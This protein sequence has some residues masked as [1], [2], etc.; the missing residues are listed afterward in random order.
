[1]TD[2]SFIRLTLNDFAKAK[3]S[4]NPA[5][6]KLNYQGFIVQKPSETFLQISN[7][8][9]NISFVGGITVDLVDG[10]ENVVKNINYNFYY[11]GFVDSNGISQI[12]FEFGYIGVDYWT[13]PLYLRITDDINGNKWYSNNFLVTDYLTNIS[14]RFDYTNIGKIY[15]IS[16]DLANYTQ[17]VRIANCYDETPI[18]KKEVKQYITSQGLQVNYRPITTF[19][20]KYLINAFDYFI[21]DRLEVLFSHQTIYANDQR[22]VV[23]DFNYDERKGDSNWLSGDFTINPQN[24]IYSNNPQ[25]FPDLEVT[26]LLPVNN[27]MFSIGQK[28]SLGNGGFIQIQFNL[29]ITLVS[30]IT[31]KLYKDEVLVATVTPTVSA[32]V[33]LISNF[34][35]YF[36][37]LAN[38]SY[39]VVI[40][41]NLVKSVSSFWSGFPLLGQYHFDVVDGEYDNSEYNNNEY[42]VD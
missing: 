42:I 16:Y 20:R 39:D 28:T 14:T 5:I 40:G 21:N 31:T 6:S 9:V 29:P 30:G 22:V 15:G 17:S 18:N 13:K 24:E 12:V 1:M 25:L 2:Y 11:E 19:L 35:S 34:S 8:S 32:S 41:S 10:C 38:G 4:D 33:F 23:S 36:S 7:S 37:T 27:A 26:S 3:S